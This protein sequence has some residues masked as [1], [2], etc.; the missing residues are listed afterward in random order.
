MT[1]GRSVA[2]PGSLRVLWD[3]GTLSGLDDRAL[4][5]RFVDRRDE[6][7]ELAFEA[8]VRRHGPMVLRVSEQLLDDRHAAE[9]A[10]QAVFLVLARRAGSIRRPEQLAPWLHGVALRTAKEARSRENKRRRLERRG[11]TMPPKAPKPPEDPLLKIEEAEALHGEIARL[12]ERY[13]AAVV[14]CDLEGLTRQEAASR[15]QCPTGTVAIRLKRARER[16][17]AR[18]TRRGLDPTAGLMATIGPEMSPSLPLSLIEST[19]K[20]STAAGAASASVLFLAKGV[21][22]T[23]TYAKWKAATAGAILALGLASTWGLAGGLQQGSKEE[24]QQVVPEVEVGRAVTGEI[25]DYEDFVGRTEV[26]HSME[27]RSSVGGTLKTAQFPEGDRVNAGEL[28]FEIDRKPYLTTLEAAGIDVLRAEAQ[29]KLAK[30]VVARNKALLEKGGNYISREGIDRGSAELSDAR[31]TLSA[32]EAARDRAE[33]ELV[34]TRIRAP[35]RGDITAGLVKPG[36]AIKAGETVLAKLEK[37]DPM[38]VGFDI[39]MRTLLR[40]RR[41]FR[42]KMFKG[43]IELPVQVGLVDDRGFPRRG[44]ARF[45]GES[46]DP[47][48]GTARLRATIPNADHVLMPG[49]FARVR[50]MTSEPHEAL[51]VPEA[52][53]ATDGGR[54]FL[55]VLDDQ[56]VVEARSVRVGN[57]HDDLRVVLEG[58]KAGER[59]VVGGLKEVRPGMTVK[60]RPTPNPHP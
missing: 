45:G 38:A 53:V 15:L 31:E 35:L 40:L 44:T 52:A 26:F 37:T 9:D 19:V 48:K 57:L 16:L 59:V 3:V 28:L 4:L 7:A 43:D 11:A 56:D 13:R 29:E 25:R 41:Q 22:M 33:L 54:K 34:A 12:P 27:I 36:D 51:L 24:T 8:L 58:V 55:H 1:R 17:R 47:S 23:M 39:D 20:A 2:A 5:A 60:P 49:M 30:A 6:G 10:F 18:L 50:L 14:L 46:L 42:D 32:S 21:Q